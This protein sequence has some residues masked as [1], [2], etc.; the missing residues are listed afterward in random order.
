MRVAQCLN[1][2][3]LIIF[4]KFQILFMFDLLKTKNRLDNFRNLISIYLL[5]AVL[6]IFR[7]KIKE[8]T[9]RVIIFLQAHKYKTQIMKNID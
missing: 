7:L 5:L 2:Q 3:V 6:M 1:C 9:Y 4:T 8:I